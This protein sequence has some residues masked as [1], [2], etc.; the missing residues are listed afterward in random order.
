MLGL[1]K[2]TCAPCLSDIAA[3]VASNSEGT[4]IQANAPVFYDLTVMLVQSS[5]MS[6]PLQS[7]GHD[8]RCA[9]KCIVF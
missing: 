1:L 9:G 2:W 7:T 8:A 5:M 3:L 4:T 6:S